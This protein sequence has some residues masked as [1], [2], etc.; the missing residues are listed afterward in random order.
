M[1][2]VMCEF[3]PVEATEIFPKFAF[4][5]YRRAADAAIAFE[6]A[7]KIYNIFGANSGFRIAFSDPSRR[8]DIV[9]NHYELE[10]TSLYIPTLFL[11][12]PPITS[13]RI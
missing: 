2:N 7:L 1:A 4:V 11:G 13:A 3:G 9:A 8:K 5:K 10:R 12:F 6:N